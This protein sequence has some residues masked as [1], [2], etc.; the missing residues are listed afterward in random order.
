ML[1]HR[2][3][4]HFLD[5]ETGKNLHLEFDDI[6]D[7][8]STQASL[9]ERIAD[10]AERAV[11]D[12]KKALYMKNHLGEVYEGTVSGV[13]EFGVFVEL[14]NTIEGLIRFEY[15]PVDSYDYDDKAQIL[16]GIRHSYRLG[17]KLQVVCVNANTKLRQIDF[18]LAEKLNNASIEELI[19][20]RNNN[21]ST[22]Y[23]KQNNTDDFSKSSAKS[24]SNKDKQSASKGGKTSKKNQKYKPKENSKHYNFGKRKKNKYSRKNIDF[25][26]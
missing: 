25:D 7:S 16:K 4:K 10:E 3:I 18:D 19:A 12:Y 20:M 11:D 22:K 8:A 5:G 21:L 1:I 13:H 15:L 23:S 6:V 26:Y 17:D 9:T 2:I 14:D 24:K